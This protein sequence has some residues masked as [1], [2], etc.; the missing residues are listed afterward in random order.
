MRQGWPRRTRQRR[1]AANTC[2]LCPV[3][4]R[5]AE[6]RNA[7]CSEQAVSSELL[8]EVRKRQFERRAEA[9]TAL[10]AI[11]VPEG[12]KGKEKKNTLEVN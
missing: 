8:L 2:V 12:Q 11:G 3:L 9:S 7:A 5:V 10:E 6:G 1:A 4:S